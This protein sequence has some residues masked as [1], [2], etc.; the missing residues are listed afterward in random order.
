MRMT[1]GSFGTSRVQLVVVPEN[2][3]TCSTNIHI[4]SVT[5]KVCLDVWGRRCPYCFNGVCSGC[6][7]NIYLKSPN[8]YIPLDPTVMYLIMY[9]RIQATY[10]FNKRLLSVSHFLAWQQELLVVSSYGCQAVTYLSAPIDY[11]HPETE[12]PFENFSRFSRRKPTA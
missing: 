4:S 3:T 6:S 2:C 10:D 9:C 11:M 5:Q 7:S 1:E 12:S 8:F